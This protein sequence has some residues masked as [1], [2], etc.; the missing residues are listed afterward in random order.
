MNFFVRMERYLKILLVLALCFGMTP[1]LSA[2]EQL[3]PEEKEKK[4]YGK[5][6]AM[7]VPSSWNPGR[8]FM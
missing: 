5:W 8:C 2:Q 3:T 7:R 1:A 4:F 6:N